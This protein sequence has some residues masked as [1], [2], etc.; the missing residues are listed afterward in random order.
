MRG[1]SFINDLRNNFTRQADS[2]NQLI[3]VNVLVFVVLNLI[4][5]VFA[6]F[7]LRLGWYDTI[8][9]WLAV[10]AYLPRLL[11]KPWSPLSYMF[12]HSGFF[13]ILFNMLWLYWMGRIFQEY[14]GN[15]KLVALYFLGGLAGAVTYMLAFNI[16]PL[17][18]S[19]LP[20]ADA[21]GASASVL[22]IVVGTATLLP[23]YTI[24]LF[25]FGNVPLKYL[26]L[27]MVV[28]DLLSL[29]GNNA[30]GHFAHL[31]G[32]IFGFVYIKQL[33]AGNDLGAWFNR[34]ADW[35][36]TRLRP[37]PKKGKLKVSYKRNTQSGSANAAPAAGNKVPQ[38]VID[39]ILD[40]IAQNGYDGLS[41]EEKEQLF[42]AS[43][44]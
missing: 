5:V 36:V 30:G 3:V 34:L 22:A 21:V 28:L 14:L 4:A 12:V 16:F 26:A 41:K 42:R 18:K 13:H 39:R 2:L 11:Q 27:V 33:R 35:L 38:E 15:K 9:R 31:G 25:L 40:K 6:L 10:P 29:A 44:Q 17:F 1:N 23:D 43:K 19:A 20:T 8:S 7:A 32:A 37:R 24:R